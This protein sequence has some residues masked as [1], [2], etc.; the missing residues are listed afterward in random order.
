MCGIA[1][2]IGNAPPNDLE[3]QV[4]DMLSVIRHRGPDGHGSISGAGIALG[5]QRLAI[6]DLSSAGHQPMSS[7]DQRYWITYNGEIYNAPELRTK[8]EQLGRVFHSTTDT[9]V[10]LAAYE[11]WGAE[12]LP[13][14]NGM[15]A[16]VIWDTEKQTAFLARDRFGVK[17]LYWWRAPS[18]VLAFASEIKEFTKLPGWSA[19]LNGQRAYDFL[20]WAITDHTD[21]TLFRG[22]H[23]FPAGASAVIELTCETAADFKIKKWYE[24]VPRE[25]SDHDGESEFTRLLA[26]SV[27]LRLRADVTVGSCL[28][29][30]LDSTSLVSIMRS[31]L[32]ASGVQDKQKT[33]SAVFPGES[34][35]ESASI[36]ETETELGV[37]NFKTTPAGSD[38][39]HAFDQLIWHQDEPFGSTSIFAQWQVFKLAASNGVKVMLD[40]QGADEQLA[41]YHTFFGPHLYGVLMAQGPLAY[42]KELSAL[43]AAHE[44]PR[45]ILF[46]KT[47]NHSLPRIVRSLGRRLADRKDSDISWLNLKAL[48]AERRDPWLNLGRKIRSNRDFSQALLTSMNLQM[49][50]RYEDRNSMAHSIEA[51]V[52]FLDYRLVEVSLGLPDSLKISNGQTKWIL[53]KMMVGKIPES[54][55]VLRRKI[56]FE[57][58]EQTWFKDDSAPR[59]LKWPTDLLTGKGQNL[60][61]R[62]EA[63]NTPMNP[64]L[65]RLLC[66]QRWREVFQ[67]SL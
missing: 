15:F 21:E 25:L 63:G 60:T 35:D 46:L 37:Q 12:C 29:G 19:K 26:D 7:P 5:H 8:L 24:I 30:G 42:W 41:G 58:P 18:G 57:A 45:L 2:L 65:F 16:F 31:E 27:R 14:F 52:P 39:F 44:T 61:A 51:R 10:I 22:V 34:I 53:R 1:A 49:L 50:L 66:F 11:K 40:G 43:H 67:V 54:I 36:A 59:T 33:F 3:N 17:P 23:N 20:C 28:S 62:Y 38:F 9:E 47:F 56:G 48:N 6:V 32:R 55:R 13:R 64:L 4:R